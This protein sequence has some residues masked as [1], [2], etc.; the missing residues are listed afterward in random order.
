MPIYTAKALDQLYEGFWGINDRLAQLLMEFINLPLA[1]DRAREFAREGFSRRVTL[2][3]YCIQNV[4]AILPPEQ[5]AVPTREQNTDATINIQ[6]FTINVFGALDNLAWIWVCEKSVTDKTG[7]PLPNKF[8]GLG[9]RNTQV[10]RSFSKDSTI[11]S[12]P[13]RIGSS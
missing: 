13:W 12:I 6:A 11:I 10:R 5:D 9:R 4:F 3:A 2:M 7:A 8:V 1:S